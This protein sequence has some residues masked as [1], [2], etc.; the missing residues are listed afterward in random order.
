VVAIY[1]TR[2]YCVQL[3]L[4]KSPPKLDDGMYSTKVT[5]IKTDRPMLERIVIRVNVGFMG[6]D[7][8]RVYRNEPAH[9]DYAKLP[10]IYPLHYHYLPTVFELLADLL[11]N[12]I[13]ERL[14]DLDHFLFR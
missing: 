13:L 12:L 5:P 3:H 14:R 11:A 8:R 10:F 7:K 4:V 6:M 2:L 1:E 9:H